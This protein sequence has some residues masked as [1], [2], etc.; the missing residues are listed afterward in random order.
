MGHDG[1]FGNVSNLKR[2][3]VEIKDALPSSNHLPSLQIRRE[4]DLRKRCNQAS[5]VL[6][7]T[8]GVGWTRRAKAA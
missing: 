1:T 7:E 3:V 6:C 4:T 2:I 8:E 5:R